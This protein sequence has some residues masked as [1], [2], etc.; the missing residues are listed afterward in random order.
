MTRHVRTS[1]C[2]VRARLIL[3]IDIDHREDDDRAD[4]A[5][6]R[7]SD[8]YQ[9]RYWLSLNYL[10]TLFAIGV[11]FMG[12]IGGYG[13][14]APVLTEINAEIG[15]SPNINWVPLASM[16]F[17]VQGIDERWTRHAD[18]EDRYHLRCRVLFDGRLVVGHPW[19]TMV[20]LARRVRDCQSLT[21][22]SGSSW[23]ALA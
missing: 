10:G 20:K 9:K 14:I 5:K 3:T 11:A 21:G 19:Q 15:P 4:V 2:E 13:L 16:S 12:G 6:G 23:S 18:L 17:D 8:R 1:T 22:D 7:N